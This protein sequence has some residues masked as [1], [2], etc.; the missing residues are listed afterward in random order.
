M[1][2]LFIRFKKNQNAKLQFIIK[3]NNLSTFSHSYQPKPISY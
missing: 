3:N 1:R 2:K